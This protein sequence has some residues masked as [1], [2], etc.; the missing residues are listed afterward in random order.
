MLQTRLKLAR[1]R[2]VVCKDHSPIVDSLLTVIS[3][4]CDCSCFLS[5]LAFS[6]PTA[7]SWFHAFNTILC[8][9]NPC[10]AYQS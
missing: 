5:Y 2:T 6:Y 3:W 7:V 1:V 4:R 10:I 8:F 9:G